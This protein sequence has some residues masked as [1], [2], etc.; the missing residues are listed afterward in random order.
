MPAGRQLAEQAHSVRRESSATICA[1][2]LLRQEPVELDDAARGESFTKG[3]S[4]V[5][6]A[7]IA[8]TVVVT[9]AIAVYVIAGEKPPVA[10]GKILDVWAHPMHTVTPSFDDSGTPVSQES[11]DQVLVFARVRLHNQSKQPLFL[12]QILTNITMPDGSINSSY[13]AAASQYERVFMA[14]PELAQWH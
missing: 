14:Y 8:A 13:A 12:H 1:M 3:T 11:F 9:I 4:H 5:L 6:V 10:T 2:S 7:S